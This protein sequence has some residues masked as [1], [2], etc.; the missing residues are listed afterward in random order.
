M[1]DTEIA[2]LALG[3]LG[4]GKEI[5]ELSTEDSAEAR[6]CRRFYSLARLQTLRD[7][8]WP[9]ATVTEAL[10]LIEEDPHEEWAY[11]YRYPV[12]CVNF[13]MI[14]S[15]MRNDTRQTR[16]PFK[17]E[18]NIVYTDKE[19]AEARYTSKNTNA[20]YYP[21]DFIQALSLRLAAMTAPLIT[22]GDPF[23]LGQ[24]AMQLY[25]YELGRAQANAANESQPD[26]EPDS[27][28]GRAR[29]VSVDREWPENWR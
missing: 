25:V 6:A 15:G 12:H 7:F 21:A 20:G 26:E 5:A 23:K 16:V 3:H 13:R 29:G 24:R 18:Q 17:I 9:F 1:T 10:Q 4:S 28:F 27:E 11:S 19:D 8:P 14:L 2:N 22:G